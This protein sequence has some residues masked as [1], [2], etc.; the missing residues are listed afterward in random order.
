MTAADLAGRSRAAF[1]ARFPEIMAAIEAQEPQS[2]ILFQDG[3]PRDISIGGRRVYD[4]EARSRAAAQVEAFMAK[5]LRLIMEQ[6]ASAGLL[7][8]ICIGLKLAM[9]RTLAE[10]QVTGLSRGPLTA[11]TFLVVF[12]V[13]LGY[14][15][16]DLIRATG[17]RWIIIVEPFVEFIAHSFQ[18]IDWAALLERVEE[19]GGDVQL[20][21]DLDPGRVVG[22][23]VHQV[24]C[25]GTPYLDGT[26][27]F[28][29][30]PLWTFAEAAKR[31]HGAAEF[32]YINRGFFEDEIVMMTNAV[33]NFANHSFRLLDQRPRPHRREMA[34]IVGAGPSLDASLETLHRIR[35]RVVLFSAGTAL[36]PLLRNGIL[37][38][39]HC[40][41]EN[42]NQ[43]PE[44]IAEARQYADLSRLCLIASA[45]VDP[46]LP[47][48]FAETILFFRDTVSSTRIL[49]GETKPVAGTAPTCVNTAAACASAL[50]FTDFALFG[51]DCGTRSEVDH[52][53]GTIYRDL[54]KWQKHSTIEARYPLE[55]EGNFGGI[56]RTNWVYDASRRMLIE[57][58]T[59]YGLNVVNCSDGALIL[60]AIPRAAE[61]FAV[62]GPP[63]DRDKVIAAI[64][65]SMVRYR[66]GELL[67]ARNLAGVREKSQA[68]YRELN[69]ILDLADAEAAD[70]AGIFDAMIKFIREARDRFDYADAIPDGSLSA[71]PRIAMFYGCRV[72]DPAVRRRLFAVFRTEFKKA[73]DTMERNTDE[74]LERLAKLLEESPSR[75]RGEAMAA[76]AGVSRP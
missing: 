3:V 17:A 30:Y 23:I 14:H 65:R 37:P 61:A 59:T 60:G 33:T 16:E 47:A 13:G 7:S 32:V 8:P 2:T 76:M 56:A 1:A 53:G 54:E 64:K 27:V 9:E 42:G 63:L 25:R 26:W 68:M 35:D 19:A 75:A 57:L 4:G 15:L 70:F 43:V 34:V 50:G 11:P 18:A 36:R 6:P 45:T 49:A 72:A 73:L 5:P 66:P 22:A 20:V 67:G 48:M 28:R 46:E 58:F 69:E 41:L 24:A 74:L 51:V 29:H 31:L 62:D 40:E 10:E 44:V 12:G 38:D 71:L 21:T 55:V 39:F 52:A